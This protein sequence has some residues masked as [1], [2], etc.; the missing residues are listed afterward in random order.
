MLNRKEFIARMA[1]A[2]EITKK[3][4]ELRLDTV[5]AGIEDAIIDGE[6]INLLGLGL[7]QWKDYP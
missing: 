7:T 6:G 1:E 3:E 5:L 4:A 2:N